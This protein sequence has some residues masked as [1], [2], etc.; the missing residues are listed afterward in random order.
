MDPFPGAGR[1]CR[2]GF[3]VYMKGKGNKSRPAR[4]ELGGVITGLG[5]GQGA[6]LK[7]I[8][9]NALSMGNKQEKLEAPG[10]L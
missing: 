7:G 6:Q 3:K 8:Y 10:E 5:V 9:T 4:D 2:E 1:A